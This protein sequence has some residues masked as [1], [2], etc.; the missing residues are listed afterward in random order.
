MGNKNK[1]RIFL[2]AE[3]N[4][5]FCQ[6]LC[7]L[8]SRE[9][10]VRQFY[11]Y[12]SEEAPP[13]LVRR[14]QKTFS[15]LIRAYR[16]FRPDKVLIFGKTLISLWL[17]I[18]FLKLLNLK[19]EIITFRYDIEHFRPYSRGIK[20]RA[21]FLTNR[22]LEKYCLLRSG[23]IIHKGFYDELKLL[24]FYNRIKN[25]PH[26]LF[27]EFLNEKL[28]QEH[29]PGTKLRNK[30]GGVH[31][32]YVGG[33]HLKSQPTGDSIWEFYPKITSQKIHVHFFIS[34]KLSKEE[35]D[36]MREIEGNNPY[37]HFRKNMKHSL[38]IR[39]LGKYDY[40]ICL[41]SWNKS[42][43][44]KELYQATAFGNKYFD[45]IS[46]KLPVII[47]DEMAPV[48]E[49][50]DKYGIGWHIKRDE[51]AHL[52]KKLPGYDRDCQKKVRNIEKAIPHLLNRRKLFDFL[53]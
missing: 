15:G 6:W 1:P 47:I 46:A 52:K 43:A 22:L 23:K 32:V 53:K 11:L 44:E 30:D 40:G 14:W 27:R 18:F 49:F 17:I 36:R 16:E 28:I 33:V 45:Y 51:V 9:F 50:I 26:H 2:T 12:N 29:D 24:P 41:D 34:T 8:L 7:A 10:I 5:D 38:L 20:N 21:H 13:S 31:L 4:E 35:E 39:E 48:A 37:F 19:T 3:R 42:L 25:K